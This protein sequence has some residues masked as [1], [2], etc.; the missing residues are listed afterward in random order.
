MQN[1]PPEDHLSHDAETGA[2]AGAS[3]NKSM[4]VRTGDSLMLIGDAGRGDIRYRLPDPHPGD[5]FPDLRRD[6]LRL[7]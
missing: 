2:N 4:M 7:H 6:T 1:V 3:P 5:C